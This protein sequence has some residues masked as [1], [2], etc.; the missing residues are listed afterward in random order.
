MT[1]VQSCALQ[2]SG[3]SPPADLH[4]KPDYRRHLARVLTYRAVRAA[5]G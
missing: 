3:S 1:G 4:A 2:I 5:S